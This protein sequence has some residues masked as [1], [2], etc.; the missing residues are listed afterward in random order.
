MSSGGRSAEPRRASSFQMTT[1]KKMGSR[2]GGGG[3]QPRSRSQP[4]NAG[5]T[6]QVSP[7]IVQDL[8]P[9][10]QALK[11]MGGS[12]KICFKILYSYS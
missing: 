11:K 2:A 7:L 9:G 10:K 5:S 6:G 12:V 4:D 8:G 1:C 3:G